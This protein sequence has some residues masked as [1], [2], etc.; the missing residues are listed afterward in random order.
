MEFSAWMAPQG[1]VMGRLREAE[2]L[3]KIRDR[4]EKHSHLEAGPPRNLWPASL[5]FWKPRARGTPSLSTEAG[6]ASV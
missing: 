3:G 6:A 2:M 5:L 4:A 1:L